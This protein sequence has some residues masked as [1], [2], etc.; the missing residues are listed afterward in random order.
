MVTEQAKQHQMREICDLIGPEVLQHAD[1][2]AAEAPPGTMPKSEEVRDSWEGVLKDR[3][4]DKDH[5]VLAQWGS[6]LEFDTMEEGLL[7]VM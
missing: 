5:E 7:M 3:E 6:S 4:I 2:E 1:L